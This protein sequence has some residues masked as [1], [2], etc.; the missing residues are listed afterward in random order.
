MRGSMLAVPPRKQT[1]SV[2]ARSLARLLSSLSVA[3]V[4]RA[5]EPRPWSTSKE[6][7]RGPGVLEQK[8][9]EGR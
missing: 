8:E 3:Q 7:A 2:G 9:R 6:Q 5:E 4:T 1:A